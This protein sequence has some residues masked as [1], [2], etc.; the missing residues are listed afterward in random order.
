MGKKDQPVMDDQELLETMINR[1]IEQLELAKKESIIFRLW[2]AV[3]PKARPR[4]STRGK[5]TRHYMP[6]N[7]VDWKAQAIRD[8][9]A[10][11]LK[12][13][14][15]SFPLLNRS[16]F[17]ILDGKHSR[18]GD[19][20]NILGSI[21][22]ALVNAS[23]NT[24]KLREERKKVLSEALEHSGILRQDNLTVLPCQAIILNHSEKRPPST[25]I[26]LY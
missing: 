19:G 21:N 6:E 14:E 23:D 17:Y 4:S 9:E 3:V 5:T 1:H 18:A 2:G 11:K 25:L 20:D 13:P 24:K 26:C 12:Y 15:H 16:A 22:D 7:Y 10:I 8:L